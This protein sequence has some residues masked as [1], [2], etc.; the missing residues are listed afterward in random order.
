MKK[1]K[2]IA[3]L[4]RSEGNLFQDINR[5]N[6]AAPAVMSALYWTVVVMKL[7]LYAPY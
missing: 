4:F 5:L 6:G 7:E 2:Y 1:F 3:A